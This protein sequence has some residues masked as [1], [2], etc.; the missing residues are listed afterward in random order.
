MEITTSAHMGTTI[1]FLHNARVDRVV[2]K[3]DHIK[4]DGRHLIL[5]EGSVGTDGHTLKEK[6]DQ[7]FGEATKEYNARQKQPS[8]RIDSYYE[9]I[10]AQQDKGEQT[11]NKSAKKL[12]YEVIL[13]FGDYTNYNKGMNET[14]ID[15]DEAVKALSEV[16]EEIKR[17]NPHLAIVGAYLHD[18]EYHKEYIDGKE[19]EVC[20]APHVHLDFV[21]VAGD[22]KRGMSIQNGLKK[23][24]QQ[25]GH[26][27]NS[28]KDTPQMA[29]QRSL[30]DKMDAKAKELGFEARH[31][32]REGKEDRR[33]HL[34]KND[35][36]LKQQ[37]EQVQE[38]KKELQKQRWELQRRENQIKQRDEHIT[39]QKG[40][41]HEQK[42]ELAKTND[43]IKHNDAHLQQQD[44][45]IRLKNEQIQTLREEHSD[46]KANMANDQ[47]K[48]QELHKDVQE[49]QQEKH[50]SEALD[51]FME[52]A[53]EVLKPYVYVED[54][55]ELTKQV[56]EKL[57]NA[58]EGKLPGK[59][60]GKLLVAF[61][62]QKQLDHAKNLIGHNNLL[63]TLVDAKDRAI[64]WVKDKF[65]SLAKERADNQAEKERFESGEVKKEYDQY[66]AS[67]EQDFDDRERTLRAWGQ[68]LDDRVEA[69]DTREDKLNDR[70]RAMDAEKAEQ[71]AIR[72]RLAQQETELAEL[73]G[74]SQ[75]KRKKELHKAL[76]DKRD[77]EKYQ[78]I[79]LAM[80]YYQENYPDYYIKMRDSFKSMEKE[81]QRI[82]E[83]WDHLK[84]SHG[85]DK[86]GRDLSRGDRYY[87]RDEDDLER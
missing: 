33:D 29:F 37:D 23:A 84:H 80:A 36:V 7:I 86:D 11:G 81:A 8:R 62:D 3:E 12:A 35:Y 18:D 16:V 13:T 5:E 79:K 73:M 31:P 60:K 83:G 6:Y 1:S 61:D 49:L 2:S 17:D 48:A 72:E 68:R 15:R 50:E 75:G 56:M 46:L 24:L 32:I 59:N 28:I 45:Q 58:W 87:E 85:L 64:N 67:K 54:T 27:G 39:K 71:Q 42:L 74:M 53:D 44:E 57:D 34:E 69:I 40:Q 65:G 14:Q 52:Q 25:D 26:T 55:D 21:P 47:Q 41:V 63:K 51:L 20:G 38:Q 30:L 9:K 77:A 4:Q 82:K 78:E 76:E 10:K 22:Y 70:A 66:C 43:L 19:V